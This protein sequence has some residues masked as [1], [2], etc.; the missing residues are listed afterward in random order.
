MLHFPAKVNYNKK[1]RAA[2]TERGLIGS[3]Q[4]ETAK[5]ELAS[6]GCGD[7]LLPAPFLLAFQVALNRISGNPDPPSYFEVLQQS[8]PA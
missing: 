8:L 7:F 4:F 2:A 3:L 5:S 1:P 6:T